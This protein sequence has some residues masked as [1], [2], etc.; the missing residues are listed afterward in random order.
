M[1]NRHYLVLLL[2]MFLATAAWGQELAK[3]LTNQDV[4]DMVGLGLSEDVIIAKIRS[5][6]PGALKFDTSVD[7][8]KALKAAQRAGF[9]D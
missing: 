8:L 4:I 6:S 2:C 1:K 7:G 3:R 9:S 5:T